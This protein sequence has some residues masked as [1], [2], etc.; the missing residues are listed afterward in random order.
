MDKPK[1]KNPMIRDRFFIVIAILFLM[2]WQCRTVA[3]IKG[4]EITVM[5]SPDHDD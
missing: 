2:T 5:V 1:N 4:N 3:Q